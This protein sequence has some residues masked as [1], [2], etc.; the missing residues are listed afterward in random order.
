MEGG[1]GQV[2]VEE[3]AIA[4]EHARRGLPEQDGYR[5]QMRKLSER[6]VRA[7]REFSQR[8]RK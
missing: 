1:A 7:V 8:A 5:D 6:K 3:N 4:L 2:M